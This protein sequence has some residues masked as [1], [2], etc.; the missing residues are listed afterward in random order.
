MAEPGYS[1]SASPSQTPATLCSSN[2]NTGDGPA[3]AT[4]ETSRTTGTQGP[5][6]IGT[7][8]ANDGAD[9]A[10]ASVLASE[11]NG[12]VKV[13]ED[14]AGALKNGGASGGEDTSGRAD[15]ANTPNADSDG[16]SAAVGKENK[17]NGKENGGVAGPA[18]QTADQSQPLKPNEQADGRSKEAPATTKAGTS[19]ASPA[20]SA[21]MG[22]QAC[23]V[24]TARGTRKGRWALKNQV[25]VA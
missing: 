7:G 24:A 3:S 4:D 17:S 19:K 1:T 8:S 21:S 12:A 18:S 16:I 10:A 6:D 15:V 13:N 2:Q 11:A 22:P 9:G 5:S 25:G 20:R 23:G 14:A